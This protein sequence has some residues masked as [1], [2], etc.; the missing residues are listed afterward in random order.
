MMQDGGAAED[1]NAKICPP[2]GEKLIFEQGDMVELLVGD[3][4]IVGESGEE[5]WPSGL[6][7]VAE[8]DSFGDVLN[9]LLGDAVMGEGAKDVQFLEGFESGAICAEVRGVGA[10]DNERKI[11]RDLLASER[12]EGVLAVIAAIFVVLCNLRNAQRVDADTAVRI[13]ERGQ[14]FLRVRFFKLRDVRA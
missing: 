4:S 9:V 12:E 5:T 13:G 7:G 6:S 8:A 14:K 3:R 10:V 2:S 11:F 1:A